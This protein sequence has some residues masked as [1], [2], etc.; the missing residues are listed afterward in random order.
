MGYGYAK[1][2]VKKCPG[3]FAKGGC[4]G[5][6]R[7]AP[8]H[9][10]CEKCMR[11]NEAASKAKATDAR[12]AAAHRALDRVMDVYGLKRAVKDADST[13]ALERKLAAA[14]KRVQLARERVSRA[15]YARKNKRQRLQS[16]AEM[17]AR[18]ALSEASSAVY[19]A[20][21]ALKK[22]RGGATD[23]GKDVDAHVG[24]LGVNADKARQLAAQLERK[25]FQ[26]RFPIEPPKA[27][28][29]RHG[30]VKYGP[31][32]GESRSREWRALNERRNGYH[33]VT[34]LDRA[35]GTDAKPKNTWKQDATGAAFYVNGY[36][37]GRVTLQDTWARNS[38]W[39]A[40]AGGRTKDF[41]NDLEA[42]K[43]WVED[44]AAM[45]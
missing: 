29:V 18:A 40:E 39:R 14:E 44:N 7:P 21:E 12:R 25:G 37:V 2:N 3:T 24:M 36:R 43:R 15:E 10:Y 16:S 41:R 22:A 23:R 31:G 8:G 11:A 45:R 19:A 35:K 38:L 27:D 5:K 32:E 30:F 6:G 28:M 33:N 17:S 13:A 42:A 9:V 20:Q 4:E 1:H 34:A 26:Y